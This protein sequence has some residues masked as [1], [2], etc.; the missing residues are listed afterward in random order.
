MRTDHHRE[1]I[2]SRPRRSGDWH[3]I[4]LASSNTLHYF[5]ERPADGRVAIK[6][7]GNGAPLALEPP[8]NDI[9]GL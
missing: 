8:G 2:Y 5:Q 6:V 7:T 4:R 9:N 1:A 3:Y